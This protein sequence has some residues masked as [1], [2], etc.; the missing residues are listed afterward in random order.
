[1][2]EFID[3]ATGGFI[4]RLTTLH[5]RSLMIALTFNPAWRSNESETLLSGKL[6]VAILCAV[7]CTAAAR[8][9]LMVTDST[10][11]EKEK[12]LHSWANKDQFVRKAESRPVDGGCDRSR[13]RRE[14]SP[15]TN[16]S[17]PSF[18]AF[19]LSQ[20]NLLHPCLSIFVH[21]SVPSPSLFSP[22]FTSSPVLK[23]VCHISQFLSLP[24]AHFSH[25]PPYFCSVCAGYY[26]QS[27]LPSFH[28][29]TPL[30]LSFMSGHWSGPL[31]SRW[32]GYSY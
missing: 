13:R 7:Y 5:T 30:P 12:W 22:D 21:F 28:S 24:L 6:K 1:M 15:F 32:G 31:L 27:F 2:I 14:L 20:W 11:Q 9:L 17:F 10:E 3:S 23:A 18:W 26:N 4:S 16:L 8:S 19:M 25:S 29:L